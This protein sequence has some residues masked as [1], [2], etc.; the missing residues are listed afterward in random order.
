[1]ISI[2]LT[3]KNVVFIN[4]ACPS[5]YPAYDSR[6]G[7]IPPAVSERSPGSVHKFLLLL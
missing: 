4:E 3:G 1:M 6:R 5:F 2:I 7:A